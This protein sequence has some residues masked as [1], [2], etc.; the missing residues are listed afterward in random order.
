LKAATKGNSKVAEKLEQAKTN[1]DIT[2]VLNIAKEDPKMA[3]FLA[4]E[5]LKAETEED[6]AKAF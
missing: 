6:V 5:L 1:K 4:E 2:K 3:K